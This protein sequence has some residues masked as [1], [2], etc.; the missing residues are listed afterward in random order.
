MDEVQNTEIGEE[1][2][3]EHPKG[4]ADSSASTSLDSDETLSTSTSDS[5]DS[6]D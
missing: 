4:Q 5:S 2:G 1:I 3:E 6:F